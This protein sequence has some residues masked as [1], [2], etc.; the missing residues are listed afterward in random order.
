MKQY[1][2]KD[3]FKCVASTKEEAIQ[4][5]KVTADGKPVGVNILRK[6]GFHLDSDEYVLDLNMKYKHNYISGTQTKYV[7]ICVK[8]SSNTKASIGLFVEGKFRQDILLVPID[9][10]SKDFENKVKEYISKGIRIARS[11]INW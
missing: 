1:T 2:F 6:L 10:E 8:Y 4:Q 11:F 3:G 5:H 7:Y 9:P